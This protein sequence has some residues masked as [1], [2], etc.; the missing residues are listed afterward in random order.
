MERLT[1][2]V[3]GEVRLLLVVGWYFSASGVSIGH[4]VTDGRTKN[5]LIE[6]RSRRLEN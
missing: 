5:W 6:P 3:F 1:V 4:G 2:M